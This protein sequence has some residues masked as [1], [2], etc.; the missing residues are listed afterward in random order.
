MEITIK[1][2]IKHH[3]PREILNIPEYRFSGNTIHQISGSN[4]AG[5]ST[6]F[7][8]LSLLD[9]DYQGEVCFD[10]KNIR[11]VARNGSVITQVFQKPVMLNRTVIENL[12]YPLKL[13]KMD[14]DEIQKRLAFYLDYL[15]LGVLLD[16]KAT[17]LSMGEAQKVSLIR[18]LAMNTPILLLDEP[19]SAMDRKSREQSLNML[20]EHQKMNHTTILLISHRELEHPVMKQNYLEG[21]TIHHEVSKNC[22][23]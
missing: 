16:Q 3:P 17:H 15:P 13:K 7:E 2:L 5:K 11:Q 10:A 12:R 22:E 23:S 20:I 19:F 8:I 4:G 9:E 21:G 1:N 18:G 14:A 6:L